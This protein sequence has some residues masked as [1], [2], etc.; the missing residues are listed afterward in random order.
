MDPVSD[1]SIE[2]QF[3]DEYRT[4]TLAVIGAIDLD[5]VAAVVDCLAAAWRR[6]SLVALVGNGGSAAT[7]SHFAND[8]VKA[9]RV[10]GQ[11]SLRAV[12]LCDNV[13]LLTAFANDEGY[14]GVFA[15]QVE[16]VLTDGDVLIAISASGNSPNVLQAVARA[17]ELGCTTV[18]LVGFGGGLLAAS[19]D[20]VV[21]VPSDVGD[22]GPVEDAHLVLDHMITGALLDIISGR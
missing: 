18:G 6:A 17:G 9:T 1:A 22:Y 3:I 13:S 11:P 7:A 21:H 14:E 12:S 4:R 2:R 19:A 5:A 16:S 20:L 8:L 10:P 15:R